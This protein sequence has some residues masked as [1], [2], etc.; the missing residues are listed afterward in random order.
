M[1][2]VTEETVLKFRRFFMDCGAPR[3]EGPGAKKLYEYI[4]EET[5]KGKANKKSRA[6]KR[7]KR[8]EEFSKNLPEEK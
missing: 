5:E 2:L 1:R 8:L 3:F 6:E 7:K 4:M